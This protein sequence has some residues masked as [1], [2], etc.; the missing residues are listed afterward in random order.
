MFRAKVRK[1]EHPCN[2][3]FHCIKVGC[4]GSTLHG[5]VSMMFISF[6]FQIASRNMVLATTLFALSLT[7][8]EALGVRLCGK[9]LADMLDL[10][11][12]GR[13][14]HWSPRTSREYNGVTTSTML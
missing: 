10:V 11:C 8:S 4:K 12:D 6:L 1:N 3:V 5:L 14:F 7:I 13:G 2:P 9:Q